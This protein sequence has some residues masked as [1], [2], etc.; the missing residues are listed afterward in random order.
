LRTNRELTSKEGIFAGISSG[1]V[2]YV[3]QRIASEIDDGDI[4]CLLAR[5]WV[6]S[7][8]PPKRGRP[9]SKRPRRAWPNPCGGERM[10]A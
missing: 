3:A 6:E 10:S 7:T 8:C 9:I 2:V 1:A 5:R 4:V